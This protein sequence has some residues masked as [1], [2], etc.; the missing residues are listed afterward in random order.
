[1]NAIEAIFSNRSLQV[2]TTGGE[3]FVNR[4]LFAAVGGSFLL[5]FVVL[6]H[7]MMQ[8]I[9]ETV[10]LGLNDWFIILALTGL[11]SLIFSLWS[12]RK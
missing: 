1:M 4:W 3:F 7:P 12:K 2:F 5:Q 6:Y 10:P 9:F 8:G 11:S